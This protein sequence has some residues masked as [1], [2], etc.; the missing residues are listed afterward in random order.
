MK[1]RKTILLSAIVV[2]V[3]IYAAQLVNEK[4]SSIKKFILKTAPASYTITSGPNSVVLAGTNGKWTVGDRKYPANENQ[5]TTISNAVTSIKVLYTVSRSDA[6]SVLERYGLNKEKAITVTASSAD[7]KVLRT[8]TVG[9]ESTTGSQTYIRLDG[10]R[11]IYLVSGSLKNTF[12]KTVDDLRTREV[13]NVKTEDITRI[14]VTSPDGNWELNKSGTPAVWSVT[15][16]KSS[17]LDTEK[18]SSWVNSLPVLNAD[19]WADETTAVPEKGGTVV[20]LTVAGKPVSVTVYTIGEG[21][22]AKY[23]GT[24]SATPYKF[25]LSKYSADKY[26]K[27]LSELKK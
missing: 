20:T 24:S 3:A 27:K 1:A 6:E 12:N 23:L 4:R 18:V 2:L 14:G 17:V 21:D 15:G 8:I 9:K 13:Y 5:V 11:D 22:K 19:S 10:G 26:L 7:G 16:S 25:Y